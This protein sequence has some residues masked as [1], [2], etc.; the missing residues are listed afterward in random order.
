MADTLYNIVFNGQTH[1]DQ[2]VHQVI[3]NLA[4]IFKTKP[5][6]IEALFSGQKRV[7]KKNINHET[8][9]RYI[10]AFD[11]AGAVCQMEPVYKYDPNAK[12]PKP[13]VQPKVK[14]LRKS[15]TCPK[16]GYSQILA[17]ECVRCGINMEAFINKKTTLYS[18][19]YETLSERGVPGW[20]IKYGL[21]TLVV[22]LLF[23]FFIPKN[24][25]KLMHLYQYDIP[26][27]PSTS[28]ASEYVHPEWSFVSNHSTDYLFETITQN[29]SGSNSFL[30]Q[31]YTDKS[32]EAIDS[33]QESLNQLMQGCLCVESQ[34]D[35]TARI[36]LKEGKAFRGD[37]LDP[38][39]KRTNVKGYEL[40]ITIIHG[41]QKDGSLNTA[42]NP[43]YFAMSLL[44]LLPPHPM[45]INET[46]R[47]PVEYT[48]QTNYIDNQMS[49]YIDMHL[50]EYVN[51]ENKL[52]FHFQNQFR[53]SSVF[54]DNTYMFQQTNISGVC[55]TFFDKENRCVVISRVEQTTSTETDGEFFSM[56]VSGNFESDKITTCV[57]KG[58][59]KYFQ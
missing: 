12:V 13:A 34:G 17:D 14:P 21:P 58:Y 45:K 32:E 31:T 46:V 59:Q 18:S 39:K 50:L 4:T 44:F 9:L 35:E 28:H 15:M 40:P 54:N 11:Q 42:K 23:P 10:K 55:D 33:T 3:N 25:T 16:C 29:F 43:E 26:L 41:M 49:G 57:C 20:A 22:L 8:A 38:N 37:Y 24:Q 27:F 2:D 53:L 19:I 6:K 5:E 36:I 7:V 56:N 52:C 30:H 47:I 48:S 51:I 1:A